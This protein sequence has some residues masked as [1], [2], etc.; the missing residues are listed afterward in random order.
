[1]K[2]AIFGASS[3]LPPLVDREGKLIWSADEKA[4][5][6]SAQFDAKQCRNHFQQPHSCD[7]CLVMYSVAF[8]S[9]FICSM[10]LDT[11]PYGENDPD[12]MFPFFYKQ[13][14][15]ELALSWR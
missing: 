6:L 5:L 11:N 8:L 12:G 15:R 7:S 1:M 10:L 2:T 14:A 4:C 3:S 13:V 9:S